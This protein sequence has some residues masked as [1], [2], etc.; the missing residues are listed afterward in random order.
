[1]E[2][3]PIAKGV[4][5]YIPGLYEWRSRRRTLRT[6]NADYC[7]TTWLSHLVQ[8]N[9]SD[10]SS[11]PK[12]VAELGPGGSLGVGLAALLSG[13]DTYYALD[14]V[15]Y[16]EIDL[17]IALL[18]DLVALF[19]KRQPVEI[20]WT[21]RSSPLFPEHILT[22]DLLAST[23]AE[24][25]IDHIRRAIAA[26]SGKSGPITI[27]YTVPWNDPAVIRRGEVDLIVSTSVL[28]HVDDL[29]NT[30]D[31][32]ARW[33]RPGGRM[34]H[35]I[36]FRSHFNTKAWNSQ[37]EYPESVWKLVVGRKPYLINRQPCSTHVAMMVARG[38]EITLEL[39]QERQGTPRERLARRW[40]GMS[41]GDLNCIE[42]LLQSKLAGG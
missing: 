19:R 10:Q 4:A 7:Y 40:Q 2:L 31:A 9:S 25:R 35:L 26:S 15:K 29:E 30:Y 24:S 6:A 34:S 23:L 21:V 5:S 20:A 13:A 11:V 27:E 37:W 33:L 42:A 36:D 18:D 8:L 41:D 39:R 12:T 22:D 17:S 14:I 38:F 1:M 16:S 28:E 3:T 32:F